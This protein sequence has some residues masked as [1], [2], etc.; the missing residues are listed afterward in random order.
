MG[1]DHGA[2]NRP[3]NEDHLPE[4]LDRTKSRSEDVSILNGGGVYLVALHLQQHTSR[5]CS[6]QAP[7]SYGARLMDMP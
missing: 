1:R 2:G 3:G 7:P 5:Q 4:E 6:L